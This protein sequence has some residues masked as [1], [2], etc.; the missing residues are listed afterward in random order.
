MTIPS[1]PLKKWI[2]SLSALAA[3]ASSSFVYAAG[4][5]PEAKITRLY[6]GASGSVRVLRI[7]LATA[8]VN[9]DGCT[10]QF[11]TSDY[12]SGQALI[13]RELDDSKASAQYLSMVQ[14]AYATNAKVQFWLV[15]CTSA[16]ANYWGQTWP[17][18]GDIYVSR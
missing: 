6:V 7:E 14:M 8:R 5:T 2:A 3:L 11:A 12:P 16:A 13:I 9:P 1:R 4:V 18:P 17:V 15:G 10:G